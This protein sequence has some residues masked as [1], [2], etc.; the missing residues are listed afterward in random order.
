MNFVIGGW[1]ELIN[2]R[3][4][5]HRHQQERDRAGGSNNEEKGMNRQ[6]EQART[7]RT[8]GKDKIEK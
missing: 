6:K 8:K 1:F 5:N 7:K 2:Q 3:L 4:D